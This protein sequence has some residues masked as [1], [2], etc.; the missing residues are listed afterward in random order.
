LEKNKNPAG[1]KKGLSLKFWNNY[2]KKHRIL[3]LEILKE[4]FLFVKG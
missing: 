2:I 1:N 3:H 4:I